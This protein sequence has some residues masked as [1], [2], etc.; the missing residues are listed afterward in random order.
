MVHFARRARWIIILGI[1]IAAPLTIWI[2]YDRFWAVCSNC[3]YSVENGFPQLTFNQPIGI[4]NA[5]DG[6]NRLFIIEQPGIIYAFNNS[7]DSTKK[8]IFLDIQTKVI[9]G[10]ELG[11]LGMAFHPL[12]STNGYVYLDYTADSPLRTVIS[13]WKINDSD[14]NELNSSSEHVLLTINQPFENHNG[15]QLA[16][17]PDGYL[18]IG[19][20]D[21]GSGGDPLGNAQNKSSLLGKILRIDVDSGSP[22]AIPADNPYKGNSQGYREEIYAYGLRNPWRFSFDTITGRLWAGD[23]GQDAWEEIDL[24]ENGK[25]YGWNIMEG[26]HC[27]QPVTC[28]ATGLTPPIYEY[29]HNVGETIIGGFVYRGSNHSDLVGKYIYGDYI[30]GQ[31]WALNYSSSHVDNLLLDDTHLAITAFGLDENNELFIADYGG[32]I[33]RLKLIMS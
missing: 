3:P 24:I 26:N 32:G 21:G 12:F 16:F 17:G 20:G 11:L 22:Y 29:G 30:N 15:G 18:Y 23:V 6:S 8:S 19:M 27:Y 33:Y 10:G 7:P 25:N 28:D 31:I 1:L 4:Y 14:P 5:H 2:L 9:A 13:R